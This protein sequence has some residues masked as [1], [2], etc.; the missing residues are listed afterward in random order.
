MFFNWQFP[1][2]QSYLDMI[3]YPSP[4]SPSALASCSCLDLAAAFFCLLASAYRVPGP[5]MQTLLITQI[6]KLFTILID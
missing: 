1:K 4:P 2:P 6:S 3:T 5:C